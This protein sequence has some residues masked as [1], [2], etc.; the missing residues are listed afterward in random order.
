MVTETRVSTQTFYPCL[1]YRDAN[2]A[3]TWLHNAFGFETLMNVQNE[4]GTV[5]HAELR[6]GDGVIMLGTARAERGNAS[7][8]DLPATNQSIYAIVD[9]VDAHCARARAA[10]AEITAEPVD[11]DYGGRGYS[12]R[13]LE[14]HGW[15]FGTY[16]AAL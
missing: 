5:A 16:R 4:D 8:R 11:E 1:F 6:L 3:I 10:G 9:D 7:P 14:G 12:A 13:D 15:S 2:A